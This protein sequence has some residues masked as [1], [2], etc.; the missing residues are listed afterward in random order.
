MALVA[1]LARADFAFA[2]F[3]VSVIVALAIRLL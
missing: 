2:P 3:A 1:F